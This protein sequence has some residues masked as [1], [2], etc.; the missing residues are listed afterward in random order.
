MNQLTEDKN[1]ALVPPRRLGTILSRARADRGLTLAEVAD[2][3]GGKYTHSTVSSI[4]RGTRRLSDDELSELSEL[5]GIKTTSLIPSRSQLIVDV[6]EGEMA[7]NSSRVQFSDRSEVLSQYLSMVYAMRHIEPGS[8]VPLRIEDL[9]VLG[10]SLRIGH[11]DL[12]ADLESLMSG[13]VS[14][15]GWRTRLLRKRILLPAAGI[16]VAF[17]GA[18]ALLLTDGTQAPPSTSTSIEAPVVAPVVMPAAEVGGAVVQERNA[19]GS[20]GEVRALVPQ[21]ETTNA[22]DP[23]EVGESAAT[24]NST[25]DPVAVG[26]GA[27]LER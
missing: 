7:V 8:Q 5:Y 9:E 24:L 11:S 17:C 3:T 26:E 16:L 10:T 13:S 1:F 23:S 20:P 25:V 2:L 4:E 6:N 22:G 15:I 12:K 21:D 18:G 27:T 14:S 19:D